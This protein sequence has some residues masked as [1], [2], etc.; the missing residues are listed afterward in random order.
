MRHNPED[1]T[2][3]D[4]IVSSTSLP[5]PL[6]QIFLSTYF[7]RFSLSSKEKNP[8]EEAS[9]TVFLKQN[10]GILPAEY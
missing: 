6:V 8:D 7:S 2:S 10:L 3:P 4:C 5:R 9:W 1:N